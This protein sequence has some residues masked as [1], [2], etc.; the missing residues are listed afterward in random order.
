V[1][2][3]SS[4]CL[5]SLIDNACHRFRGH[6]QEKSNI[7]HN[8]TRVVCGIADIPLKPN[9]MTLGELKISFVDERRNV[10]NIPDTKNDFLANDSTSS[11]FVQ[12]D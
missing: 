2:N 11:H 5:P 7:D 12:I 9:L 8:F 1:L 6:G 4:L 10:C 3:K